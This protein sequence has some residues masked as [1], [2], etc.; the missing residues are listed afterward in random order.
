MLDV[1]LKDMKK[2]GEQNVKHKPAIERE[3]LRC[4]Q[5]SAV[6]SPTTAQGLLNFHGLVSCHHVVLSTW[7]GRAKK[8]DGVQFSFPPGG[9]Q[10]LARTHG[11]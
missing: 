3:D 6:I 8:L 5:E 9:K 11:P 1:K 10:Q 2:Q 7:A 4:L